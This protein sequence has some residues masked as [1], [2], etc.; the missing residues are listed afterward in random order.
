MKLR[1]CRYSIS[2]VTVPL[3]LI[4]LLL[5]FCIGL[6]AAG[7]QP[8]QKPT[9]QK[10]QKQQKKR[11]LPRLIPFRYITERMLVWIYTALAVKF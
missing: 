4:S 7:Q 2:T 8:S 11:K 10:S 1:T 6:P 5:F 9:P 3:R